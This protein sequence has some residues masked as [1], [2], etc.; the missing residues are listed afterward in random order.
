MSI[1]LLGFRA[2]INRSGLTI[3]RYMG[4]RYASIGVTFRSPRHWRIA[5]RAY[6]PGACIVVAGPLSL[7]WAG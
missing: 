1:T 4:R 5:R 2:G 3:A 6:L 7:A